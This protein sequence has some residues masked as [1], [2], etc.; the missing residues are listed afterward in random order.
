VA[1]RTNVLFMAVSGDAA[2]NFTTLAAFVR[3][4]SAEIAML[5]TQVLLIC[6]RQGLTVG[7]CS[8]STE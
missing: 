5:F 3:E 8:P 1:C 6:D 2:A 4:R 7:R